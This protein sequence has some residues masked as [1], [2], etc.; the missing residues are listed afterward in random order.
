MTETVIYFTFRDFNF[1]CR[2]VQIQKKNSRFAV[3]NSQTARQFIIVVNKIK[4]SLKNAS[5]I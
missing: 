4:L 2:T 1:I 5:K 3:G